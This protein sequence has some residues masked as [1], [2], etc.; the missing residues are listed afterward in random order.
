MINWYEGAMDT[1][2]VLPLGVDRTEVIFD[3]Y[4]ADVSDARRA[5]TTAPASTSAERIQDEDL[6]ICASVQRGL[7]SRAYRAAACRSAAKRASTC[8]TACCTPTYGSA[9]ASAL[10]ASAS[11]APSAS[12][13]CAT[14]CGNTRV[15]AKPFNRGT[16]NGQGKHAS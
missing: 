12:S 15:A 9:V 11:F 3:F 13:A 6:A 1:N 5:R 4:F 10:C 2:L 7:R 8:S 14:L 16:D